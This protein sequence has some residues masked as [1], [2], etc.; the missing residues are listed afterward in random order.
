MKILSVLSG[1]ALLALLSGCA[2]QKQVSRMEGRGTRAVYVADYN[3]TWRAAVDA[4]QMGDLEVIT[5][6]RDHGYIGARRTIHPHTFGENVGIWVRQRAASQTEVEVV[7]RQAGPPVAWLKNWEDEIQR[8]IAANLT[9]E[10]VGA[11]PTA[12]IVEPGTSP[13]TV[14][15]PERRTV[16]DPP[17]QSSV[18]PSTVVLP[19][20][21]ET[22]VV[23][24]RQTVV[25][26][27][28]Q[29]VVVPEKQTVIVPEKPGTIV[30]PETASTHE[31]VRAEQRRFEELRLQQEAADRALANEVDTTKRE[32]LQKQ[33][34]RLREDIKLQ[35]KRLKDLERELK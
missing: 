19:E 30:V 11:A 12:V 20:R 16:I 15:V 5:A 33:I 18:P 17:V 13:A 29:T 22:V 3:Q 2:T 27:E 34:D 10:A 32:M 26:P 31:A 8:S 4:A 7:S 28:R 35:E 9:R 1:V 23:P 25:V 21:R 14:V 6:D 24:E